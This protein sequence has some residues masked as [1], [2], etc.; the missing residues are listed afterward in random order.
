MLPILLVRP[1][2]RA[3]LQRY[4]AASVV[5]IRSSGAASRASVRLSA[6]VPAPVP[7]PASIFDC[8]AASPAN[9]RRSAQ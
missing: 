3:L 9:F 2:R 4:M 6:L 1:A 8:A 7:V 5:L